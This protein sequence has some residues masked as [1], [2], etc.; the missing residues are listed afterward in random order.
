MTIHLKKCSCL[1]TRGEKERAKM[2]TI[3]DQN[4][5]KSRRRQLS[6]I[7]FQALL[8]KAKAL[9]KKLQITTQLNIELID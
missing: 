4:K 6:K 2:I 7:N 9:D 3:E 8:L 5:W 1:E